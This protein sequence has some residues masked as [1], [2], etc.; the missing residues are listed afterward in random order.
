MCYHQ[1][2]VQYAKNNQHTNKSNNFMI[3]S[4][5]HSLLIFEYDETIEERRNSIVY[6]T[7]LSLRTTLKEKE[8]KGIF[9]S[10]KHAKNIHNNGALAHLVSHMDKLS[11]H[12]SLPIALGNYSKDMYGVLRTLTEPTQVKLFQ[13]IPSALLFLDS[14]FYKKQLSILLFDEDKTNADR[15]CV[16]LVKHGHSITHAQS[17]EELKAKATAKAYDMTITQNCLNLDKS[18][19]PLQL[20]LT[21]SK[22]LIVNLPVFMDTA[23]EVLT[24]TTGLN[25][26]KIKHSVRA[27]DYPFDTAVIIASMKFKGDIMGNFFLIFPRHVALIALEAMLGEKVEATDTSAIVDGVAELCNIITG[28]AKSHLALKHIKVLFELPKTYLTLPMAQ[29]DVGYETGVW[30]EMHLTTQPFYMF[31]TK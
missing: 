17:M 28:S 20:T 18:L 9:I 30:I 16:G 19:T 15:L 5:H 3:H 22:E 29:S 23:A 8:I 11:Q 1:N 27:M 26:Q 12:I 6:N 4:F 24:T 7:L 13:T 21:L 2:H 10:L 31:V 14:A 25:T